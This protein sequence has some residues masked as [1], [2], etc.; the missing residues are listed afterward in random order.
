MFLNIHSIAKSVSIAL[1]CGLLTACQTSGLKPGSLT[2]SFAP[3]GWTVTQD[4]A[5]TVYVCQ[6][7]VCKS[8]EVV[9]VGPAKVRGDVE[10]AVRD[11]HISAEL[12]NALDNVINVASKGKVHLS[13]DRRIVTKT[14]SGFDMSA[15]FKAK[16]G[17]VYGALRIFFQNDR[18][19]AV[20]SFATSRS[21]AKA[22][23]SRFL[24]QTTISRVR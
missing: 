8:P 13:T 11:D 15:R 5:H 4:G 2:T 22:N 21:R 24:K 16:D 12:M 9:I 23:L 10:T 17:Y 3:K 19:S 1:I 18:G 6:P 7:S 14:Y 20:A